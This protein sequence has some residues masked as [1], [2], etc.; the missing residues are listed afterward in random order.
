MLWVMWEFVLKL[1]EGLCNVTIH[2]QVDFV[3]GVVPIQR[4]ANVL[5]TCPVGANRIIGFK[6]SF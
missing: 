1:F 5:I 4:D 2:R 3:V 6:C